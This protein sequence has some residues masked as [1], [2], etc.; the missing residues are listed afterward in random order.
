LCFNGLYSSISGVWSPDFLRRIVQPD[1]GDRGE[2][3]GC[4]FN[5]LVH[6]VCWVRVIFSCK[7]LDVCYCAC[8]CLCSESI[9]SLL[10]YVMCHGSWS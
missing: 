9:E 1:A 8:M 4:L 2:A 7:V 6:N 3:G 10:T 5:W